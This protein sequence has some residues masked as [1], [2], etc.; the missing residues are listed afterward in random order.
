MAKVSLVI[1]ER[2]QEDI[3]TVIK[4]EHKQATETY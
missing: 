4:Q 2:R 3:F 1:S